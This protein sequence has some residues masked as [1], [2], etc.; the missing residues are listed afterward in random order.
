MNVLHLDRTSA[1]YLR[2]L[3]LLSE[4]AV[5]LGQDTKL[6][7]RNVWWIRDRFLLGINLNEVVEKGMENLIL[8][9]KRNNLKDGMKWKVLQ[10]RYVYPI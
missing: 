7:K 1:E 5:F 10:K 3:C 6:L 9:E 4:D 2:R 8:E